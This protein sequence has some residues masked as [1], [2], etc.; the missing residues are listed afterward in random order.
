LKLIALIEICYLEELP[1]DPYNEGPLTYK[2]IGDNFTLYSLG[3]DFD[4]DEGK[5][6]RD[7]YGRIDRWSENS[8]AMFW[9]VEKVKK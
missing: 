3:P 5:V 1:Q 7:T 6:G 4:D 8:D 9:P 2:K